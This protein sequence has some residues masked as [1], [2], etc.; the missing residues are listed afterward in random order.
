MVGQVLVGRD[1]VL[2]DGDAGVEAERFLDDGV[3]G[4]DVSVGD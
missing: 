2:A 3:L 4:V 1:A